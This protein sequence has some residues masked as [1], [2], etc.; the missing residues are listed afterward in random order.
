MY[1]DSWSMRYWAERFKSMNIWY[2]RLTSITSTS[3]HKIKTC[4]LRFCAT[5]DEVVMS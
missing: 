4:D 3:Y 2:T 1:S 5:S